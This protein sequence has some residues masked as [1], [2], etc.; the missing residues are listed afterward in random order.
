[1]YLKFS[2]GLIIG[3]WIESVGI[4]YYKRR[5]EDILIIFDWNKTN[6]TSVNNHMNNIHK[7]LELKMTEEEKQQQKLLIS[8]HS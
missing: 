6:E 7:N 4:S 1:M 5:V 8:F 2:E 3:H